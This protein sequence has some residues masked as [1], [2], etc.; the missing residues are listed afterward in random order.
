MLQ[1]LLN[2]LGYEF[3]KLQQTITTE[4]LQ[5]LLELVKEQSLIGIVYDGNMNLALQ[6]SDGI[7]AYITGN[8]IERRRIFAKLYGI[9]SKIEFRNKQASGVAGENFSC[10][11]N[12]GLNPV[13]IKG[14]IV[15]IEYPNPLYRQSGDIDLYFRNTIL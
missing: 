4:D 2:G 10:F 12:T 5:V 1:I 9:V 13:M 14:Q 11:E 15:A 3:S 7:E 8:S 6:G